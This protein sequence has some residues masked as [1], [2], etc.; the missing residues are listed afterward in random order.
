MADG[1]DDLSQEQTEKLLQFQDLTG[2]DDIA[3]CREVLER[4][5]WDIEVA[6]QDTFNEREGAP[7]VYTQLPPPEP[8]QPAMNLMPSDQRIFTVAS[9]RPQGIIQW[10][11]YIFSFPIRFLYSTLVDL[12]R[13]TYRLIRPDPRQNVTDPTGDVE[14]FISQFERQYGEIHP[15]FY[16]GSYS[17]ALNDAK[18]ELKFLLVYLHGDDHQDTE[19]F[20]RATLC[21]PL[22][23]EFINT[24]TLFW[25]C[26]T[27][28]PEGYRVSQALKETTY[29]F[30][31]LI[32]LR[33]NRMTVIAKIEGPIESTELVQRLHDVI[34]ENEITIAA[35]RAERNERTMVQRLRSEQDQAYQMSLQADQEKERKRQL[36]KEQAEM[37][38]RKKQEAKEEELRLQ[39]KKK[40]RKE[41][42][43]NE[44]PDEPPANDAD[45]IR[46]V[47]KVPDGTR[48]ERRFLRSQST[49]YLYYYAFCH[50]VCPDDFHIVTNF[51]R[52]VLPCQPEPDK[53][54]PPSFAECGLGKN[55]MLFV[56]DNEA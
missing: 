14:A 43:R 46:I 36:Q 29:P 47:L 25:A 26:N 39:Q 27:N 37:E 23:V 38:E 7:S 50:D 19:N 28:R 35:A 21:N 52:R 17:Q 40:E 5:N 18:Q 9:R 56:Q 49:K 31:A 4:H 3:R 10:G 20:C 32:V 34:A 11:Y 30:L 44:I 42:L 24:D 41:E 53:P 1:Q 2:I 6:V 22:V 33:N 54:D 13:F 8:R 16:R 12:L 48:L 45:A 55:E 51:P 15:V